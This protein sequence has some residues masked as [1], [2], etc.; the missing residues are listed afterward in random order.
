L[1]SYACSNTAIINLSQQR[2]VIKNNGGQI[3]HSGAVST[4]NRLHPTPRGVFRIFQKRR[5]H[6]SNLYPIKEDGVRGGATMNYMLKF[7]K[8][9]V[10]LHQGD[11]V[12]EGDRSIPVS[13]GCV[14]M[15]P[16]DAKRVYSLLELGDRVI[17][18]GSIVY[19]DSFNSR[20]GSD[21][22]LY[23]TDMSEDEGYYID[24]E[25]NTPLNITYKEKH[26]KYLDKL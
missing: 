16:F 24:V 15:T 12:F 4:G 7:T 19:T 11:V 3:I 18:R 2:L 20:L 26:T 8:G 22:M 1:G 13:H 14:R 23:L 25:D 5:Y 10:A 6:K 9:G 17:V 21:D